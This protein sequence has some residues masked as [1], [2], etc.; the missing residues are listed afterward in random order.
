MPPPHCWF[1]L[2]GLA[3]RDLWCRHCVLGARPSVVA[4]VLA[5]GRA[6][7]GRRGDLVFCGPPLTKAPQAGGGSSLAA[8]RLPLGRRDGDDGRRAVA[9]AAATAG[10]WRSTGSRPFGGVGAGRPPVWALG[11]GRPPPCSG[12]GAPAGC[13]WGA[14]RARRLWATYSRCGA[15]AATAAERRLQWRRR[16]GRGMWVPALLKVSALDAC[17]CGLQA[18]GAHPPLAAV[19]LAAGGADSGRLGGLLCCGPSLARSSWLAFVPF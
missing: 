18:L 19:A 2:C 9:A 12:L 7:G 8:A 5:A 11:S 6:D 10:G 17:R 3:L 4:P 13:C 14:E 16:G 15:A 1:S